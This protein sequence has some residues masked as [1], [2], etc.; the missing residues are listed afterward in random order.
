MSGTQTPE[1]P[2]VFFFAGRTVA[3][4]T[5]DWARPLPDSQVMMRSRRRAVF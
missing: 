4:Q 1:L 2:R 5:T 3:A